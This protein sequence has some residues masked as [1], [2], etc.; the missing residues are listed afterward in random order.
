MV[1]HSSER[2]TPPGWTAI[3]GILE[4]GQSLLDY[5]ARNAEVTGLCRQRDCKRRA[6]IDF[7]FWVEKGFGRL[8]L[9]DLQRMLRCNRPDG[10][11]LDFMGGHPKLDLALS[12]ISGKS[13]VRVRF[14][15]RGQGCKFSR[16]AVV[17]KV[18]AGLLADKRGDGSTLVCDL[19]KLLKGACGTCGKVNWQ[20]DV[21]WANTETAG[22]RQGLT[23][24]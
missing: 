5:A 13:N 22:W 3:S 6:A 23:P 9:P 8:T 21:I 1:R 18:I 19:P 2:D 12:Q 16:V 24:W 7:V 15:C 20:V 4:P 11:A 10:C 17:E 14:K